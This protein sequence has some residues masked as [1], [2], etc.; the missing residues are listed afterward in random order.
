MGKRSDP[1]AIASSARRDNS[2]FE[3]RSG[4]ILTR[5]RYRRDATTG[6]SR[7]EA[8]RSSRG[9]P[10]RLEDKRA[11]RRHARRVHDATVSV[12][13]AVSFN[14]SMQ[15]NSWLP[16]R[17]P[18]PSSP[19]VLLLSSRHLFVVHALRP[20]ALSISETNLAGETHFSPLPSAW[21]HIRTGQAGSKKRHA[22]SRR[23]RGRADRRRS[24]GPTSPRKSAHR[25]ASGSRCRPASAARRGPRSP[26]RASRARRRT[27]RRLRTRRAGYSRDRSRTPPP[28]RRATRSRAR[29]RGAWAGGR[30][31]SGGTRQ[32]ARSG[33]GTASPL[34][35]IVRYMYNCT[36]TYGFRFYGT[37]R[38]LF[39]AA[40]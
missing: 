4:A 37:P 29:P 7:L 23:T 38:V 39:C 5:T 14:P 11:E 15:N 30:Q 33:R 9:T 32:E 21:R 13:R 17:R 12:A 26:R 18:A 27:H 35:N 31:A 22:A 3:W 6:A 28:P 36:R 34:L 1:H 10:S 16:P 20:H 40:Q 24:R 25:R 2:D 19:A 8:V